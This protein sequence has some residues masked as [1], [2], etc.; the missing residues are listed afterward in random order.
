[1]GTDAIKFQAGSYQT[2]HALVNAFSRLINVT[3]GPTYTKADI[4]QKA[5]DLYDPDYPALTLHSLNGFS[6][7][8]CGLHCG[9][10]GEAI[11]DL[12]KYCGFEMEDIT[13]YS[14]LHRKDIKM[15]LW[16]QMK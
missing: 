2:N 4:L 8:I 15:T 16:N 13:I 3:T 14:I 6:I 11:V 7:K 9:R 5:S 10:E 12:L 1:M